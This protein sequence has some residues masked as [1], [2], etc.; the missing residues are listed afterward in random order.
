[1]DS[2]PG[3]RVPRHLSPRDPFVVAGNT[4]REPSG[5]F[6]AFRSTP[7][8]PVL[9]DTFCRGEHHSRGSHLDLGWEGWLR[10]RARAATLHH[11][12]Q[13]DPVARPGPATWDRTPQG[14]LPVTMRGCGRSGGNQVS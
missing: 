1:M 7:E 11:S 4:D 6:T 2:L 8:A 12:I 3:D 13:S 14:A 9:L 10:A 5:Q